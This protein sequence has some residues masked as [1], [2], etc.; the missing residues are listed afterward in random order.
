MKNN[1]SV[2]GLFFILKKIKKEWKNQEFCDIMVIMKF[3]LMKG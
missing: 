3:I 2:L 1:S